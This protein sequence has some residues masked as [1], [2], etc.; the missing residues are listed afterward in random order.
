MW[1]IFGLALFVAEL[2]IPTGFVLLLFGTAALILSP[3]FFFL[4]LEE[5][6]IQWIIFSF[7]SLFLLFFL[8]KK[9][10]DSSKTRVRQKSV[11]SIVETAVFIPYE[12]AAS[13]EGRGEL[14]GT[15]WTVRNIGATPLLGGN[16]YPI[17]RIE[18]LTLV[19]AAS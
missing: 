2:M 4:Q 19:V 9:I 17:V 8:R 12:I 7:L 10:Q 18:G 13:G 1:T 6:G 15:A 16:R 11:N 5:P 3:V 14:R